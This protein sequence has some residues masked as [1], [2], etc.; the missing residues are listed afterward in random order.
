MASN[1]MYNMISSVAEKVIIKKTCSNTIIVIYSFFC[2][3][4]SLDRWYWLAIIISGSNHTVSNNKGVDS[5]SEKNNRDIFRL[6][7]HD[8]F[9]SG[10]HAMV[11]IRLYVV[12]L[13]HSMFFFDSHVSGISI[14]VGK[15]IFSI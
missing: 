1:K 11:M 6:V 7:S 15:I 2:E 4:D 8:R 3:S 5:G 14:I 9:I 10:R 13:I 12:E